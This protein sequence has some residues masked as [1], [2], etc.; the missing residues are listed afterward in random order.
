[1]K[2]SSEKLSDE[3]LEINSCT[4]Q[5]ISKKDRFMLRE[6]GRIDYHILYILNG[7]CHIVEN[8][9]ETPVKEGNIILYRPHERQEYF[10][11][12]KDNTISAYIHFSGTA[13]EQLLQKY[14]ILN[15]RIAYVGC[16][17]TLERIFSKMQDEFFSE[18][19]FH[20]DVASA[21]LGCFLATAGRLANSHISASSA[22][23]QN[24]IDTVCRH[25][26]THYQDNYSVSDYAAM[27]FMS[28]G[29]FAHVFKEI[30]GTSPKQY[31]LSIKVNVAC[32][33]L[34]DT[35]MSIEEVSKTV[36]ID[37]ANYFSRMIKKHT[38][39]SP[40]KHR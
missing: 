27:C 16:S 30:T 2:K 39:L 14:G 3:Y 18:K 17:G 25:M 21:H 28:E 23:L 32:Q 20:K 36:G 35:N 13:C 22:R 1:M 15:N 4:K 7:V 37:D 12:A 34:A 11:Y 33:L 5:I 29:R 8:G 9:E 24:R 10:F 38:G 26:Y 6:N 31:I 40:I 19:S